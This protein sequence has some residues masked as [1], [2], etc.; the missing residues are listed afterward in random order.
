MPSNIEETD[1]RMS[2]HV[3]NAA[4]QFSKHLI[5]TVNSDVI[6]TSVTVFDRLESVD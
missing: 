2:L 4:N 5:K 6:V 3:N 1:E